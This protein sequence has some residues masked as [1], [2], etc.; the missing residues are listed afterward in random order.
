MCK[1][2]LFQELMLVPIVIA[3]FLFFWRAPN[4]IAILRDDISWG[5]K[6]CLL[7]TELGL[8]LMDIPCFIPA[9]ILIVS[10]VRA[11]PLIQVK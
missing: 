4:C 6:M 11:P 1:V 10:I 8:V 2:K 5:D 9:A 7:L 3:L